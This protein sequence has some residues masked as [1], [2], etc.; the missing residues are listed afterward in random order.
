[1]AA[2]WR[3]LLPGA[4]IGREDSFFALGGTSLTLTRLH[5]RLDT[6]Y[7][8]ALKLVDLFRL[9]TVSAIATALADSGAVEPAASADLSFRL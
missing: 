2:I 1:M 6:R 3:E 5:E 7:R 9:T 4:E 8:G